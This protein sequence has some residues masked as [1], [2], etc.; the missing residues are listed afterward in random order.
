M[1][2]AF[3]RRMHEDDIFRPEIFK[4]LFHVGR[5]G[6]YLPRQAD[7]VRVAGIQQGS[8]RCSN[9]GFSAADEPAA[10]FSDT[11]YR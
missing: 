10:V 11:E 2:G 3:L 6:V 8:S 4:N 9:G 7:D 5:F 1:G